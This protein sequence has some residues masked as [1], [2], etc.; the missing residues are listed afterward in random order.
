MASYPKRTKS[1]SDR[2]A[3]PPKRRF[4]G[5]Q[6]LSKPD[7]EACNTSSSARKLASASTDDVIVHS[8]HCYRIIDFLTVFLAISDLILCKTCKR[9]ITFAETGHRG[10]GFK[11]V[12]TCLCGRREINSGPLIHTGF[13]INRRIV[14]VMRLLGVGR[15]GVN[16]FCALMDI[17]NGLAKSTYDKIVQH[18][19]SASKSMFENACKKAVKEEQEKM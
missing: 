9:N 15:E 10:L 2:T 1:S 7:D 6:F 17:S 11:I 18:L 3:K 13:E 19:Y 4:H 16:V 12:S 8:G 14:F 5:N